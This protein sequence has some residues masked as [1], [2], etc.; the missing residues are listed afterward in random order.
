MKRDTETV[1]VRRAFGVLFLAI[2]VAL[3]SGTLLIE[4]IGSSRHPLIFNGLIWIACFGVIFT[5]IFTRF[6]SSMLFVRKRMKQSAK[7]PMIAKVINGLCWAGPFLAI[8]LFPSAYQYF[9]LLGIGMGNLS[10]FIL[11]KTINKLNNKE[12]LIVGSISLI[13][14]PLAAGLDT[15][16]FSARSD[17]A[18]LLSRALIAVAYGIAGIYAYFSSI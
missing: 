11:M 6:R 14:I 16:F 12:Q 8:G 3:L 2:S 18:V 1:L 7:W 5:V 17:I 9:I 15:S 4:F 13:S 10:T